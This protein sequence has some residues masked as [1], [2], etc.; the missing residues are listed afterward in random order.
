MFLGHFEDVGVAEFYGV[1]RDE[2]AGRDDRANFK[3]YALTR[4]SIGSIVWVQYLYGP[5]IHCN[6]LA[7]NNE[8]FEGENN[9]KLV[10]MLVN[11]H[12]FYGIWQVEED[13]WH[14]KN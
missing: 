10:D 9:Q 6:V 14:L 4:W 2:K 1:Q 8:Y 3:T 12:I 11:Q 5:A 13:C 7:R